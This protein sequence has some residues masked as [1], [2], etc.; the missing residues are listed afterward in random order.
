MGTL[1][2]GF[3]LGERG[4]DAAADFVYRLFVAFGVLFDQYV[5]ADFLCFKRGLEL[6]VKVCRH[7]LFILGNCRWR[8]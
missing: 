6:Q 2:L 1:V 8:V 4:G 7:V 5:T 3:D